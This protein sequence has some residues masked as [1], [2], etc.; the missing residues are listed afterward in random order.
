MCGWG[1]FPVV[2]SVVGPDLNSELLPSQ[3]AVA[4]QEGEAGGAAQGMQADQPVQS[5]ARL[6]FPSGTGDRSFGEILSVITHC[7]MRGVTFCVADR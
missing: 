3:G 7:Q 4:L 1:S 6:L 2:L 5:R